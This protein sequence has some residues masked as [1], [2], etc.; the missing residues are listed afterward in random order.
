MANLVII[1]PFFCTFAENIKNR[2]HME[3][4]IHERCVAI[5]HWQ[6]PFGY[7]IV[8]EL[9]GGTFGIRQP[10]SVPLFLFACLEVSNEY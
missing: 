5:T 4:L 7:S 10:G 6:Q 2:P 1:S 9:F 8:G 3:P